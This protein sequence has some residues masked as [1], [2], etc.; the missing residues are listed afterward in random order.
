MFVVLDLVIFLSIY[1][2]N[3]TISDKTVTPKLKEKVWFSER[4][5]KYITVK[6]KVSF[7]FQNI[8][9]KFYQI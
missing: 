6:A 4:T 9:K 2:S 3:N 7:N 8:K 1:Y 5:S